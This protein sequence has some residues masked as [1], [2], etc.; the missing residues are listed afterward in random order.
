MGVQNES[1]QR[2]AW[3]E[4]LDDA[5][6]SRVPGDPVILSDA[7]PEDSEPVGGAKEQEKQRSPADD[8]VATGDFP[9][10]DPRIQYRRNWAICLQGLCG[11]ALLARPRECAILRPT[12]ITIANEK[13]RSSD[14]P[15]ARPRQGAP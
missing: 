12:A 9:G 3:G 14:Q 2:K 11:L 10:L 1:G 13:P 5:G 7:P 4:L 6:L 15:E 8:F